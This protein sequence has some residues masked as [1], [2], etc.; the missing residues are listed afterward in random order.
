MRGVVA[1]VP[2]SHADGEV[3]AVTD[4]PR[5]AAVAAARN[6]WNEWPEAST[7]EESIALIARAIAAHTEA[8]VKGWET[9]SIRKVIAAETADLT[10]RLAAAEGERDRQ[11]D[12]NVDLIAKNYALK[13]AVEQ[14]RAKLAS[15]WLRLT[16]ITGDMDE[17]LTSAGEAT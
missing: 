11:Y 10:A 4:Q 5:D 2:L 3:D 13:A 12:E 14:A 16:A 9:E 15:F 8:A 7:E 6:L 1:H 17:A